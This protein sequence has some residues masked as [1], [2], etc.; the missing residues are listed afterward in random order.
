MTTITIPTKTES[1]PY[2]ATV[3]ETSRQKLKLIEIQV[4]NGGYIMNCHMD[5]E[6]SPHVS[7]FTD[8]GELL[9]GIQ[10]ALKPSYLVG[11]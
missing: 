10:C 1:V 9:N 6:P 2:I 11:E 4:V 7:V 8:D 3:S 5:K